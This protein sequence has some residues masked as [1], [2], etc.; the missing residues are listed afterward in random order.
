VVRRSP[1]PLLAPPAA[2]LA[3]TAWLSGDGALAWCAVDLCQGAEPGYSMAGLV[4][5]ALAGGI[6]PAAWSGIGPDA[7]TLF[8]G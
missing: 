3:F 2:L 5:Q 4:T 1:D 6:P 7:L 8:A